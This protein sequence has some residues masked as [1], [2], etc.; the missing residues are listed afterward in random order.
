MMEVDRKQ[1]F[2]KVMFGT[3]SG[4]NGFEYKENVVNVSNNWNPSET[5]P[6]EMGGFNFSVENKIL[7]YLVRGDT[8][9]DVIIP[10]DAEVI[11]CPSESCPHGVFRANKIIITN[12]RP[13]TDDMAMEFY[14]KA[15]LPEKSFYKSLAGCAVRGY[16]NTA[17]K[18][19][20]D[21]VN[22]NNIDLVISEVN[23]FLKPGYYWDEKEDDSVIKEIYSYLLQIQKEKN[24]YNDAK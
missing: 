1:K 24:M 11:D 10:E 9:C 5:E 18:I 6:K 3:I 20:E 4:A 14:K 8:I 22:I 12:I 15:N 16:R 21:K 7:R 17:L 2:V 23:D 19:I 13:M